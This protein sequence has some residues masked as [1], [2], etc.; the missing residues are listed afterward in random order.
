[1]SVAA[2][3]AVARGLAVVERRSALRIAEVGQRVVV[4]VGAVRAL[5]EVVAGKAH[6]AAVGLRHAQA[7]A[8]ALVVL[9]ASALVAH[10]DLGAAAVRAAER[11]RVK[12]G[13]LVV[14]VALRA[15]AER[16]VEALLAALAHAPAVAVGVLVGR[17]AHGLV[18]RAVTV[19]VALVA[20]LGRAVVNVGARVVTVLGAQAA[21]AA[22]VV[23]GAICVDIARPERAVVAVLVVAVVTH[24]GISGETRV[25]VVVAVITAAVGGYVAVGVEIVDARTVIRALVAQLLGAR[26]RLALAARPAPRSARGLEDLLHAV[27][28]AVA[29]QTVVVAVAVVLALDRVRQRTGRRARVARAERT[30]RE[31]KRDDE[32]GRSWHEPSRR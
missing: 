32:D 6:A 24:L 29:K 19:V 3:R 22:R 15:R 12:L 7:A 5:R 1:M 20:G 21:I 8:G 13:A 30:Q 14:A 4:V 10:L 28:L 2:V 23:H 31:Q 16:G 9:P 11:A 18:D 26:R 17:A 27:R 25:V